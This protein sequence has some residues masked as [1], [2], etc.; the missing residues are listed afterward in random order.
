MDSFYYRLNWYETYVTA[1]DINRVISDLQWHKLGL[2]KQKISKAKLFKYILSSMKSL[3]F[4]WWALSSSSL[5]S[6]SS[7][8]KHMD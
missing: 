2:N 4:H 3:L 5:K 6:A 1:F 8:K 7:Y